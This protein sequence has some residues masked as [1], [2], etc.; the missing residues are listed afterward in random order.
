MFNV[1]K[2]GEEWG[3]TYPSSPSA[4]WLQQMACLRSN[5][6]TSWWWHPTV[7]MVLSLSVA[8]V[9]WLKK[10]QKTKRTKS[11][12]TNTIRT[13][14]MPPTPPLWLSC[15]LFVFSCS[16]SFATS[17]ECFK[18]TFFHAGFISPF[19]YILL[20]WSPFIFVLLLAFERPNP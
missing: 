16:C 19:T 1:T 13:L 17:H 8:N 10:K 12:H 6:E 5:T 9:W 2:G 3:K 15:N 7:P 14:I 18:R 20:V 4:V 11:E